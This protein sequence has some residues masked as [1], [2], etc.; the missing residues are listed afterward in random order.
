MWGPM[1]GVE[2]GM[3]LAAFPNKGT[4]K[5]LRKRLF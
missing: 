1:A 2:M 3:K 5:R 4:Q